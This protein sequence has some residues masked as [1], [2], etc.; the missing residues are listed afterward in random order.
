MTSSV[1][2]KKQSKMAFCPNEGR[3]RLRLIINTMTIYEGDLIYLK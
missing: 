2:H 3:W 1:L